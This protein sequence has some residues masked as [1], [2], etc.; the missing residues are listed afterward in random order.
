MKDS[1]RLP[2]SPYRIGVI[3]QLAVVI[4][5]ATALAWLATEGDPL[6]GVFIALAAG[7]GY[8]IGYSLSRCPT[9]GKPTLALERETG[10]LGRKR[11]AWPERQC[12]QC[13]DDL[14]KGRM[15]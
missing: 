9:C 2:L 5:L 3:S 14:T 13:G 1:H 10:G 7:I 8:W 12:S 11:R 4:L 15:P 6:V